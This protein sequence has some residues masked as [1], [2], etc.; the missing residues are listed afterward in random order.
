MQK[1]IR[2]IRYW[3]NTDERAE[4]LRIEIE[5]HRALAAGAGAANPFGNATLYA[6]RSR[7]VWIWNWASGLAGDLRYAVRTIRRQP[8]YAAVAALSA[9]LGVGVCTLIFGLVNAAMLQP[10]PVRSP[11][12][13]ATV[14]AAESDSVL[15]GETLSY[16]DILSIRQNASS[17][18]DLAAFLPLVAGTIASGGEPRRYWGSLVTAN[19]FDIAQP[20][21]EAG[22]GFRATEDDKLG[23]PPA[24]VL[25]YGIWQ[26]RFGGDRS[27]IGREIE[28]NKKR[29][30][31]A[32]VTAAGFKGT[33]FAFFSDF[34]IPFSMI[35]EH[36][37]MNAQQAVD[38]LNR[39]DSQWLFGLGRL[40]P[41]ATMQSARAE[42]A[43]LA[44]RQNR[45]RRN[46]NEH[47][48]YAV[49]RAGQLNPIVRENAWILFGLIFA[50]AGLVLLLACAN[51]ANLL[52]ARAEARRR[53]IST[54]LAI[55]AG[56]GRLIRQLVTESL[57]LGLLG[58]PAGLALAA[59]AIHLAGTMRLPIEL[60]VDFAMEADWRVGLFCLGLCLLTGLLF[61]LVPAIRASR[62]E[63]VDGLKSDSP[64]GGLRRWSL[65]NGLVVA[66]VAVSL[67][68][69]IGSA[70]FLRSLAA[71]HN[72]ETGFGNRNLVM[73]AVDP[74][75]L[76]LNGDQ[77]R[78]L[79]RKL[80]A[81]AQAT[82]GV[83]TAS[84][85][86]LF[87]LSLG[88]NATRVSSA[89]TG[90]DGVRTD[91]TNIRPGYFTTM[92]IPFIAG[93]EVR[94]GSSNGVV[95]NQLLAERL[96]PGQPA[97]GRTFSNFGRTLF[98]TGVV[99]N[100]KS[101]MLSEQPPPILYPALDNEIGQERMTLGIT[102]VAHVTGEPGQMIQ[103]LRD[104]VRRV[105]P[106]LP[107]FDVRT[108][109]E[110]LNRALFL[111][112]AAALLFGLC[113]SV[114]LLIATIGVYGVVSYAVARRSREIGI[115]M[116]LG[117]RKSQVVGMILREGLLLAGIGAV[118]GLAGGAAFGAAARSVLY[119][120][121]SVDVVACVA[122]PVFLLLVA[123]AATFIPA[124][125][126][127]AVDPNTALRYE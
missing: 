56:R 112:K 75:L 127:A 15:G 91:V 60:P 117:A 17:L 67:P 8:G 76:G 115:R 54:R 93:E 31:V 105:D 61:G 37:P 29:V 120:T 90:E 42:L 109:E 78:A 25:S 98:I 74:Q 121:G 72:A 79:I 3:L 71:S 94:E 95:V 1:W 19:Y 80:H 92:G 2:R 16:P 81:E 83:R 24:I 38:R 106:S 125:R 12:T 101:R 118:L 28:F 84:L 114:A 41:G 46:A 10:L 22:G 86:D 27:L 53:E 62:T 35:R 77:V 55:G 49:E 122:V 45:S 47:R 6:E 69:L 5:T 14:T 65:R 124:R 123:S 68:L 103:P 58:G 23:A 85:T 48:R 57:V 107:I 96:F 4:A 26:S 82:P 52:L 39:Y 102:V 7:E 20:R 64:P 104:A 119:G 51:V 40:R 43:L 11:G 9:T 21:F 110:H 32:G 44:E 126:A 34:W 108:F 36:E 100:T 113:G 18:D 50:S 97:V 70:L 99:A 88:G 89:A 87:P 111:P 33:E 13:L 66:Q 63:L 116:A 73:L 59:T 30:R